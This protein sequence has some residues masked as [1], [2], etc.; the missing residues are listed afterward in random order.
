MKLA[1]SYAVMVIPI[2]VVVFGAGDRFNKEKLK[3]LG[4]ALALSGICTAIGVKYFGLYAI[5]RHSIIEGD[6]ALFCAAVL[7]AFGGVLF[8]GYHA[9]RLIRKRRQN[10]F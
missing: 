6:K 3:Y 1:I 8:G 4:I 10:R 2:L 9:I 5:G 7:V